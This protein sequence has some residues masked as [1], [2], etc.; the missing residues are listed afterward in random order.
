MQ[1][2]VWSFFLFTLVLLRTGWCG[3]YWHTKEERMV[4]TDDFYAG[5]EKGENEADDFPSTITTVR[6]A[7]VYEDRV[8]ENPAFAPYLGKSMLR[9]DW[10]DTTTL[11]GWSY[12]KL[13]SSFGLLARGALNFGKR[14]RINYGQDDFTRQVTTTYKK[15][16][17]F[18]SDTLKNDGIYR[19]GL[20]LVYR[21]ASRLSLGLSGGYARETMDF[22]LRGALS[23]RTYSVGAE[24]EPHL[25]KVNDVNTEGYDRFLDDDEMVTLTAGVYLGDSLRHDRPW[26]E[27][28]VTVRG[29]ESERTKLSRQFKLRI[30]Y[31]TSN[32]Q[33]TAGNTFPEGTILNAGLQEKEEQTIETSSK[34]TT[35]FA[36]FDGGLLGARHSL[37]FGTGSLMFFGQAGAI[38]QDFEY[39]Y[40]GTYKTIVASGWSIQY[41]N[42]RVTGDRMMY[43]GALGSEIDREINENSRI[44][45]GAAVRGYLGDAEGTYWSHSRVGSSDHI[46]SLGVDSTLWDGKGLEQTDTYPVR[47]RFRA[48]RLEVPSK[49]YQRFGSLFELKLQTTAN[50]AFGVKEGDLWRNESYRSDHPDPDYENFGRLDNLDFALTSETANIKKPIWSSTETVEKDRYTKYSHLYVDFELWFIFHF[51]ETF[52]LNIAT[53]GNPLD[54]TGLTA[55]IKY[56]W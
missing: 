36:L 27:A 26:S 4:C 1:R 18:L 53:I 32:F 38:K 33:D 5:G 10:Y 14:D 49:F 13:G 44:H 6:A 41:L 50:A 35:P 31:F 7:Q 48:T 47:T 52:E 34:I 55:H 17:L 54:L 23:Q 20:G 16:N 37:P 56:A 8:R 30:D 19:G 2:I 51:T 9:V 46:P 29:N 24:I 11:G 12:T 22:N 45:L 40:N 39:T 28:Y 15:G 43:E 3:C 21:P 25:N 42:K